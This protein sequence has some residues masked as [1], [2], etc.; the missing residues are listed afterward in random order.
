MP[1]VKVKYKILNM[2]IFCIKLSFLK[3]VDRVFLLASGFL[4]ETAG[5]DRC[6][7]SYLIHV[8]TK[9]SVPSAVINRV[10][11]DTMKVR[12]TTKRNI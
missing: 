6:K 2:S 11:K 4:I 5:S 1:P 9:S 8:S 12:A 3:G 7:I 10:L